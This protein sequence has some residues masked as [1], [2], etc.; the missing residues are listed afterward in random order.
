M[1]LTAD[2]LIYIME[3]AAK[4]ADGYQMKPLQLY[5]AMKETIQGDIDDGQV[6]DEGKKETPQE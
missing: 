6:D 3:I 2:Q 5:N 1:K 4:N